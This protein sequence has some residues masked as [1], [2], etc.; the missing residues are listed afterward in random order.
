MIFKTK[1]TFSKYISTALFLL[2][3]AIAQGQVTDVAVVHSIVIG[4][5]T[6]LLTDNFNKLSAERM[7]TVSMQYSFSSFTTF[8]RKRI[9]TVWSNGNSENAV[10][11]AFDLQY[12]D[13][14]VLKQ[15]AIK[16]LYNYIG[17]AVNAN[18]VFNKA[19]NK[20]ADQ[21]SWATVNNLSLY[22]Y[23]EYRAGKSKFSAE[24]TLPVV[25][26][27]SRPESEDAPIYTKNGLLYASYSNLYFTSLHNQKALS[28]TISYCYPI[29]QTVT[30][31][32]LYKYQ[33]KELEKTYKENSHSLQAGISMKFIK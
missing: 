18:P 16:N 33:Y 15:K 3:G 29:S 22:T 7:N 1:H 24:L 6:N 23:H 26:M 25:G 32:V 4:R 5:G 28:A 12:A 8:R 30:F 19:K 2:S 21:Y 17:Y 11:T 14:Y 10:V 9:S 31:N 13:A 27:A 20:P